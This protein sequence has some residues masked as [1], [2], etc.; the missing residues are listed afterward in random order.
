MGAVES[1]AELKQLVLKKA[2]LGNC[3]GIL[4]PNNLAR[5]L[6]LSQTEKDRL[7]QSIIPRPFREFYPANHH[8]LYPVASLQFGGRQA[9]VPPATAGS[10]EL[11]K[12]QLS[13]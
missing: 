9:L 8:R 3:R 13:T 2:S 12:G 11:K 7:A 5:T 10:R 6:V 1:R 4:L